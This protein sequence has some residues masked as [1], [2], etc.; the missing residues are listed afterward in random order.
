MNILSSQY[1]QQ[2][3]VYPM[4]IDLLNIEN[5]KIF[6]FGRSP[7]AQ[8]EKYYIYYTNG[9]YLLMIGNYLSKYKQ[10]ATIELFNVVEDQGLKNNI[11][12]QHKEITQKHI[13]FTQAFIQQ[14]NNTIIENKTTVSK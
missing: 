10:D 7:F 4:V 1:V 3:D 14:Y 5:Q 13:E 6:S 9:E 2:I 8:K 11:A 12:N